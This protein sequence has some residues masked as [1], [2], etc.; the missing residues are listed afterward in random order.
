MDLLGAIEHTQ[1]VRADFKSLV[2]EPQY[3][4]IICK[5]TKEEMENRRCTCPSFGCGPIEI[6]PP[7]EPRAGAQATRPAAHV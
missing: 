2:S 4:H 3:L 7:K 5:R 1:S 6:L